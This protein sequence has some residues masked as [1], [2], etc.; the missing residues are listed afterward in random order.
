MRTDVI[1]NDRPRRIENCSRAILVIVIAALALG[2]AN[3]ADCYLRIGNSSDMVLHGRIN[4]NTAG[5][6]SLVNLKGIGPSRAK[7]I[8][9]YRQQ[10]GQMAFTCSQDVQ[11]VKGIGPKTGT[12]MSQWLCFD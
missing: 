12:A 9:E 6:G 7:A 3:V 4:P 11:K 10:N 2:I 5:I 8:I 1:Y